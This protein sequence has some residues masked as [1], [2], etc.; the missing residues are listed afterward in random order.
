MSTERRHYHT[1]PQPYGL[2]RFPQDPSAIVKEHRD[3]KVLAESVG[4]LAEH[5]EIGNGRSRDRQ[6]TSTGKRDSAHLTQRIA[7]DR[8]DIL[9]EMS[10]EEAFMLLV[11]SNAQS[12]LS[13]LEIGVHALEAVGLGEHGRGKEGGLSEYARQIGKSQPYVT[14]V[15]QAAEVLKSAKTITQVMVLLDKAKHL[16]AIHSAP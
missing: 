9:E 12:E 5:G 11:L 2:G 10:D 13:P 14:Q 16:A 15:R 4:P 7:R 1:L 8:P 3:P 6:S